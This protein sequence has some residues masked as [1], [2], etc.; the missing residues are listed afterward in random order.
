MESWKLWSFVGNRNPKWVATDL[1][2]REDGEGNPSTLILEHTQEKFRRRFAFW[3]KNH[4]FYTVYFDAPFLQNAYYSHS[5][6]EMSTCLYFPVDKLLF[7]TSLYFSILFA[8]QLYLLVSRNLYMAVPFSGFLYFTCF[9]FSLTMPG[10]LYSACP[11]LSTFLNLYLTQPQCI[12]L[13][14]SVQLIPPTQNSAKRLHSHH[15]HGTSHANSMPNSIN[16]M[17]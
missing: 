1:N 9:Q 13:S 11:E 6:L 16:T 12:Q 7:S 14:H 3:T 2:W 15:Q 10:N 8:A 5:S 4:H 17:N